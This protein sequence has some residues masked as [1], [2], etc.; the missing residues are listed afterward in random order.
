MSSWLGSRS[1]ADPVGHSRRLP[2]H[3]LGVS[4]TPVHGSPGYPTVD[5]PG[6][7]R[8]SRFAQLRADQELVGQAARRL[9]DLAI[10]DGYA[11][12]PDKHR[13]FTLALG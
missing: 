10:R 3:P 11:G 1:A 2:A 8:M 4:V 6:G 12:Q 5:H 7:R 9:R 13:A